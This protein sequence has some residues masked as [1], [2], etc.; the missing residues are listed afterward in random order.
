MYA[1]NAP[2]PLGSMRAAAEWEAQM[3]EYERQATEALQE[4]A[5]RA[6]GDAGAPQMSTL[7]TP[8]PPLR[9]KMLGGNGSSNGDGVS[10]GA[11]GGNGGAA[12]LPVPRSE[13]DTPVGTPSTS[14]AGKAVGQKAKPA[15]ETDTDVATAWEAAKAAARRSQAAAAAHEAVVLAG[16]PAAVRREKRE[17]MARLAVQAMRAQGLWAEA[18]E[19]Q[20]AASA[21]THAALASAI[22]IDRSARGLRARSHSRN[23]L[24][25]AAAAAA[26]LSCRN[27]PPA[28]TLGTYEAQTEANRARDTE[29]ALRAGARTKGA[30]QW[31]LASTG[32][33]PARWILFAALLLVGLCV[34]V[35]LFTPVPS[36][37]PLQHHEH[38]RGHRRRDSRRDAPIV[39]RRSAPS[40]DRRR[41]HVGIAQ[42]GRVVPLFLARLTGP[43]ATPLRRLAGAA[44]RAVFRPGE[45]SE[46][47]L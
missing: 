35:T 47:S 29:A 20:A 42:G 7:A 38:G 24:S 13:G 14:G 16:A 40:A 34:G 6:G 32:S 28:T 10:G 30:P 1:P 17:A 39:T 4:A 19:R 41:G 33:G 37:G 45:R 21:L 18:L 25:A 11:S 5:K 15:A 22:D 36:S 27:A 23:S 46:T 12:R 2:P 9:R 26:A 43:V 31:T 8:S 3:D 44:K